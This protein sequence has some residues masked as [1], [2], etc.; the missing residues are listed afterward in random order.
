[1][2]EELIITSIEGNKRGVNPALKGEETRKEL[3]LAFS[4]GNEREVNPFLI[5]EETRKELI[6]ASIEGNEMGQSFLQGVG[7]KSF[8]KL[9]M[10]L[11]HFVRNDKIV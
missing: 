1:M 8:E 4:R 6:L 9:W 11:L 5:G 3:I 2:R 7:N 10:I